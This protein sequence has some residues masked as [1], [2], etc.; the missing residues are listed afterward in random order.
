[1]RRAGGGDRDRFELQTT[2]PSP[3]PEVDEED[4]REEEDETEEMDQEMDRL[5]RS[6]TN[7][8]FPTRD[9]RRIF[10]SR[11]GGGLRENRAS[12][13]IQAGGESAVGIDRSPDLSFA[14]VRENNLRGVATGSVS[15]T[16]RRRISTTSGHHS[17]GYGAGGNGGGPAGGGFNIGGGGSRF[18]STPHPGYAPS[19]EVD[20]DPR[21]IASDDDCEPLTMRVL[22]SGLFMLGMT[23]TGCRPVALRWAKNGHFDYPFMIPTWIVCVKAI[24]VLLSYAMYE[25]T[26]RHKQHTIRLLAEA[27]LEEVKMAKCGSAGG[28][29][30]AGDGGAA[31][32]PLSPMSSTSSS[33][34][35]MGGVSLSAMKRRKAASRTPSFAEQL[36]VVGGGGA[37]PGEPILS[38]KKT[39]PTSSYS[40]Q[41]FVT[42]ELSGLDAKSDLE[43]AGFSIGASAW[44]PATATREGICHIRPSS[45]SSSSMM[46]TEQAFTERSALLPLRRTSYTRMET[47]ETRLSSGGVLNARGIRTSRPG[48]FENVSMSRPTYRRSHTGSSSVRT[49]V[50]ATLVPTSP[51]LV[52]AAAAVSGVASN[53]GRLLALPLPTTPTTTT[54]HV[55]A[56]LNA[57]GTGSSSVVDVANANSANAFE[58]DEERVRRLVKAYE[59]CGGKDDI[60]LRR[61]L[62]RIVKKSNAYS[63]TFS[64]KLWMSRLLLLPV[65]CSV[66]SDILAFYMF[67]HVS[68]TTYAVVKQARLFLTA[69]MFRFALNR[70]VTP[71]QWVAV[72]QLIMASALFEINV[73][74]PHK[75]T[76]ATTYT[77]PETVYVK[78]VGLAFLVVKVFFDTSATILSDAIFKY[79]SARSFPFPEQQL[80][81]AIYSLALGIVVLP[82]M[83]WTELVVERRGFFDGYTEGAV[84]SIF[85]YSFYG[86]L[87]SLLLRYADSMVK[88]FQALFGVMITIALDH[89]F[90]GGD[91]GPVRKITF[92][93]VM[94]SVVVYKIAAAPAK[95]K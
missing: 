14:S 29:D 65:V 92:C 71:I 42:P 11:G 3:V 91:F 8:D 95:Q 74:S 63:P 6:S 72:A 58:N 62:E 66:L 57:D 75:T 46:T 61:S 37:L 31:V 77:P 50:G 9:H 79:L 15:S 55:L 45:S 28:D 90:Y 67:E 89:H 16:L 70:S 53:R 64:T 5:D 33:Y 85:L 56:H 48:S 27:E 36:V 60:F 49:D 82:L 12:Y 47:S 7:Q 1:M 43:G 21:E 17:G 86:V 88:M 2:V 34:G 35:T 19:V 20:V 84:V 54:S 76:T 10:T 39:R 41:S 83:C 78:F 69:F 26:H 52:A 23:V 24:V 93:I 87:I 80:L 59:T 22:I 13:N 51:A 18:P 30:D 32:I 25:I 38:T 81:F 94:S 73:V 40:S 4:E 44:T 68:P